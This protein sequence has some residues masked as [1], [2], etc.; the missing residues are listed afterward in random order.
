MKDVI[1]VDTI[2][3]GVFLEGAEVPKTDNPDKD[4]DVYMERSEYHIPIAQAN[5][6][7]LLISKLPE[8]RPTIEQF[9]GTDLKYDAGAFD[10]YNKCLD[11][12]HRVIDEMFEVHNEK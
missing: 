12:M 3:A 7:S 5:L 9:R 8:K 1:S 4:L 2:L 6:H 10:G 11:D